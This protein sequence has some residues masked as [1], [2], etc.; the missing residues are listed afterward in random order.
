VLERVVVVGASLAGLRACETLRTEGFDGEISLVGA[1]E[2]LPYDRP[3]LSKKVLAGEWEPERIVLRK[4]EDFAALDLDLHLGRRARGLDLTLRHVQLAGGEVLPYDGLIVATGSE[5]RRL[6]GQP[7]LPGVHVLR[8]L[9]DCLHLRAELATGTARVVVVGAGFI[10]AEV[11]ATA[12]GLGCDVAVVEALAVPLERA[13]GPAM[14]AACAELHRDHGVALHLAIGVEAI[15]GGARVDGVR[16]VDGTILPADIVVVGI[17]VRPATGW[18]ADSGLSLRDG[19][20]C[21]ATLSAGVPGVYAA[22]DCARWPH[23]LFDEVMRVEHWTNAAEQGA[24]AAR[25]LLAT[26]AGGDGK[27]YDEVPFFW[28][29]QYRSRIQFLGR[30]GVG[31]DVQVVVGDVDERKF[32]AVYSHDGI[33][34]GAL[35]LN[36]PRPLMTFRRLIGERTSLADV[37]T[38]AATF[39]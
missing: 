38:H 13:L 35:G 16:L 14:G 4:P 32:V 34:R 1:E 18:L 30:A 8:S 12:C 22:G 20:V 15:T 9:D 19:V 21:D 17:G 27:P 37:V 28:S 39:A 36:L 6:P 31:D 5:V 2:H 23:P 26:A 11:A 24:I 33:V 7:E 10:G 29:D 3:P 25:N